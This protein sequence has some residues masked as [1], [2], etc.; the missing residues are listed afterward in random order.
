MKIKRKIYDQIYKHI[1]EKEI[2][3]I[4]GPRQSG[5]TTIMKEVQRNLILEK[6]E[7]VYLNLD[8]ER[9]FSLLDS[10]EKLINYLKATIR[11]DYGYV[12]ID[13]FQKKKDAGIFLKGMY[14]MDLPYKFIIS[15]SGSIELKEKTH[16]SLAGRKRIFIVYP[17]S[18]EEFFLY[19]T[20]YRYNSLKEI[21]DFEPNKETV[22]LE[23]YMTYGGYPKVVITENKEEKYLIINE[24]VES[25]LHKDALALIKYEKLD[26][27][28][29]L[30]KVLGT[31]NGSMIE[32]SNLSDAVGIAPQTIKNYIRYLEETHVV[33]RILPYS[34]KRIG[35][36]TKMPMLY[37][38]DIGFLH[39]SLGTFGNLAK[40]KEGFLFQN[41]AWRILEEKH[42]H[43]GADINY[44]RTKD[45]Q[46]VDFVIDYQDKLN[47]YEVK[48][49][50][51][52][53]STNA[54]YSFR[55]RYKKAK[56]NIIVKDIKEDK[57]FKKESIEIIP[58]FLL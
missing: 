44:W 25:F 7:T 27:L 3:M 12:F 4:I 57:F 49:S 45:H 2:T 32:Y 9:D 23:E 42:M 38:I 56:L 5:K 43:T 46:E 13:E 6:K 30:I 37:F 8:I 19:K 48:Y 22:L 33:K 18:L 11:S 15:G 47:A 39:Y 24:I 1:A 50:V 29:K 16:E 40:E 14:D 31:Y 53:V 36:I 35:E 26:D 10:Q 21:H 54:L 58:Y 55:R 52:I 41:I 17:V 20:E 34:K 51:S 28:Q